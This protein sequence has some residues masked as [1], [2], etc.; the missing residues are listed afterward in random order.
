MDASRSRR[1]KQ[2]STKMKIVTEEDKRNVAK[3]RLD[4]LENDE[5]TLLDEPAGESDE[6]FQ[7]EEWDDESGKHSFSEEM[8]VSR[9]RLSGWKKNAQLSLDLQACD[10][11]AR[12]R[13]FPF[14]QP[15]GI[16]QWGM[17]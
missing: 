14:T 9:V 7:L 12:S 8:T 3:A 17:Y 6:E 4:A 15:P 5:T 1:S 10:N 11:G 2:V 16:L 13:P